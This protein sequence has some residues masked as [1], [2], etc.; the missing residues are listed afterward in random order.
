MGDKTPPNNKL[1]AISRKPEPPHMEPPKPDFIE[2]SKK[3]VAEIPIKPPLTEHI[4]A[5]LN[6]FFGVSIPKKRE[7]P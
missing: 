2:E 1:S 4:L 7:S 5:V 6:D 3:A